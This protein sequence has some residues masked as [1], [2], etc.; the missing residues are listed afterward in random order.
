M[1]DTEDS[2]AD[3]ATSGNRDEHSPTTATE[4]N[5]GYDG[6]SADVWSIGVILFYMLY[7][8]KTSLINTSELPFEDQS[9]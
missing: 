3:A 8:C 5:E 7:R 1:I 4:K 2:T 6:N 9:I